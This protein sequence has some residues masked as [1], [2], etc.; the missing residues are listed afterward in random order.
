MAEDD[1]EQEARRGTLGW[2]AAPAARP[3]P[4]VGPS[5]AA[6]AGAGTT[7]TPTLQGLVLEGR[8]TV[9]QHGDA[10]LAWPGSLRTLRPGWLQAPCHPFM[11]THGEGPSRCARSVFR[12]SWPEA[13]TAAPQLTK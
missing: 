12:V 1:D 13:E 4:G 8:E 7:P 11:G 10:S 2:H 5:P 6:G 3:A 9:D